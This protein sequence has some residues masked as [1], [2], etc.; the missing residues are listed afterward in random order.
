MYLRKKTRSVYET[1]KKILFKY[2]NSFCNKNEILPKSNKCFKHAMYFDR[3]K[4]YNDKITQKKYKL[5]NNDEARRMAMEKFAI[6]T[7]IKE[8]KINDETLLTKQNLLNHFYSFGYP[9]SLLIDTIAAYI[10]REI[11]KFTFKQYFTFI[12]NALFSTSH[13]FHK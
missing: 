10:K 11:P 1:P 3:R 5:I 12:A 7:N 9:K 6:I 2:N 8:E 4:L 13:T